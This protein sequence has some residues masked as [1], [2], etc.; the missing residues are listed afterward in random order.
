MLQPL[1]STARRTLAAAALLALATA[2]RAQDGR[3]AF[4]VIQL[5][6]VYRIDAVEN[7]QAGGLGRIAT[8]A[9]RTR[10]DTRAPVMIMHAG[11]FIAP[12]LE[13]RYF[14]GIQ[15]IDALNFLHARAPLLAVPGNHEFDE[16]RPT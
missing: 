1:R 10:R 5:N 6:D 11:D 2:A 9:E 4:S 3:P 12:S 8:L 7:G 16:R 14:A 15:M 13:S